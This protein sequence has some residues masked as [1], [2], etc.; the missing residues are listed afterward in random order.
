M[1]TREV[2]E[3]SADEEELTAVR[4]AINDS[5]WDMMVYKQYIP[6]CDEFC[7]VGQLVLRG[8]RVV[9]PKKLRPKVLSLAHER[10][11]CIV[12]TKQKL[13]SKVCGPWRDLAVDLLGPSITGEF[14]LVVIDYSSGYYEVVIMKSTVTA[15]NLKLIWIINEFDIEEL[16]QSGSKWRGRTTEPVIVK[17]N[18]NRTSREERLEEGTK[19]MSPAVL[20]FGQKIRKRLPELRDIHVELEVRDRDHEQKNK[21][22]MYA[23]ERRNARYS[24]ILPGDKYLLVTSS[25]HFYRLISKTM[26]LYNCFDTTNIKH[27][28]AHFSYL[29]KKCNLRINLT[30]T[31]KHF[32]IPCPRSS[33]TREMIPIAHDVT[34]PI[35]LKKFCGHHCYA[36]K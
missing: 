15:K 14:I 1:T 16:L 26:V 36:L 18:P 32:D 29:R 35:L 24:D 4:K 25:L 20:L 21:G 17:E 22:K 2:E 6:C 10:H 13:R 30:F 33:S 31:T 23:D 8:T 11:L 12:G 34:A 5:S 27:N 19:C 7:V 28:F 9:I 3:V